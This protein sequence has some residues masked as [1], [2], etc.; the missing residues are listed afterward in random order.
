LKTFWKRFIKN[1]KTFYKIYKT[2][3][4]TSFSTIYFYSIISTENV[5]KT[6]SFFWQW[7]KRLFKNSLLR[8]IILFFIDTLYTNS[9]KYI[10]LVYEKR[11]FLFCLFN[12]FSMC[13]NSYFVQKFENVRFVVFHFWP[14]FVLEW[15]CF[16]AF[17]MIWTKE[18][19]QLQC[20]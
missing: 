5:L 6:F 10:H 9:F 20:L 18:Q 13:Y 4:N 15:Y 14:F 1:P 16:I 19:K 7:R 12:N 8:S 3:C 17:S 2:F 11:K